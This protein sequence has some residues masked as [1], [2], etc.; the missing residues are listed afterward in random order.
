MSEHENNHE[1]RMYFDSEVNKILSK[2]QR[3]QIDNKKEASCA[4]DL[5]KKKKLM[6]C[7]N[8]MGYGSNKYV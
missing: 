3:S 4:V 7:D 5:G 1:L 2:I 8:I 6:N